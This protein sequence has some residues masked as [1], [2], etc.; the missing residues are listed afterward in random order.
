MSDSLGT[1]SLRKH[2]WDYKGDAECHRVDSNLVTDSNKIKVIVLDD[3]KS[4]ELRRIRTTRSAVYLFIYLFID[5]FITIY[6]TTITEANGCTL[7]FL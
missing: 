4:R 3:Q 5:L 7:F 6:G 1:K 2:L